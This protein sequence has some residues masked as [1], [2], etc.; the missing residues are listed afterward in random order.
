M[1]PAHSWRTLLGSPSAYGVKTPLINPN[2]AGGHRLSS[3]I[4]GV[5][6]T[7][8]VSASEASR[9]DIARAFPTAGYGERRADRPGSL[10]DHRAVH[11]RRHQPRGVAV[12]RSVI[13]RVAR[14]HRCRHGDVHAHP[15]HGDH[16]EPNGHPPTHPTARSP[17]ALDTSGH[18]T[19]RRR[20][21]TSP[22]TPT[23]R[24]R[25]SVFHRS[26]SRCQLLPHQLRVRPQRSVRSTGSQLRHCE[27]S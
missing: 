15:S 1:M 4:R 24:D 5:P 2:Y 17:A 22:H 12:R 16:A 26:P 20:T 23:T 27:T 9:V 8:R 11:S 7:S 25:G 19:S 18:Y 6:P 21:T 13:D 10:Q 3:L 14:V